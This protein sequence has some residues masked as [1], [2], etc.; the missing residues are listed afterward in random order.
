MS[1]S[2]VCVQ[3]LPLAVVRQL[4]VAQ[5]ALLAQL[6]PRGE[7]V[8]EGGATQAPPRQTL[9]PAQPESVVHSGAGGVVPPPLLPAK[10]AQVGEP[11]ASTPMHWP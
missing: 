5:S 9:E 7:A 1:Q 3:K 11:E 8:G 10:P 4:P 2:Q 6:A